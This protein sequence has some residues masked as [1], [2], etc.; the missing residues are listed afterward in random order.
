MP[1]R[2]PDFYTPGDASEAIVYTESASSA[3]E[4]TEMAL[5]WLDTTAAR[6]DSDVVAAPA[7]RDEAIDRAVLALLYLGLHDGDRAWKSFDWSA[8]DRLHA[9][10]LISDPA[11]RAKSVRFTEDGLELARARFHELFGD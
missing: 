10:G 1:K 11:S 5:A 3:W 4:A 7:P 2:L 9:Q 8:L 6:P